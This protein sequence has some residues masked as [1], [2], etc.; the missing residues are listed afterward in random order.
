MSTL[1]LATFVILPSEK[2]LKRHR[3]LY[4]SQFERIVENGA[5]LRR[6]YSMTPAVLYGELDR[7]SVV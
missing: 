2:E 4:P 3:K 7:K 1:S 5:M 6:Y